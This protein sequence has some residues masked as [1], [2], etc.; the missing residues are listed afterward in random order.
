MMQRQRVLPALLCLVLVLGGCA[1]LRLSS[2]T[3]KVTV[4]NIEVVEATLM[5]QLYRV[6]LRIQNRSEHPVTLAGGS[7]DLA[8]NGRDFGS[9][10]TNTRV[11]IAPFTDA[12][13]DVRMVSTVFGIARLVQGLQDRGDRPL[14]YEISGRFSTDGL[15]HLPF[16][17]SGEIDLPR[18][19]ADAPPG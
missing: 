2:D 4:S 10:V 3:L 13:V 6:T 17:E 1:S 7:F 9:G 11:T 18:Q 8:L 15:I 19:P 16:S 12:Q 14:A 5:E